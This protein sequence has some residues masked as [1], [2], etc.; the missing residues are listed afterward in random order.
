M[1]FEY[2]VGTK[3]WRE[4]CKGSAFWLAGVGCTPG[5]LGFLLALHSAHFAHRAAAH[6]PGALHYGTGLSPRFLAARSS[7]RVMV[8]SVSGQTS[9]RGGQPFA[10]RRVVVGFR[11]HSVLGGNGRA[12][13]APALPAPWWLPPESDELSDEAACDRMR[14]ATRM[15]VPACWGRREEPLHTESV[16][17]RIERASR[18]A[19][20]KSDRRE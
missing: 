6:A 7:A 16:R 4:V 11:W 1:I 3:S 17:R 13:I 12:Q 20:I 15:A 8:P 2:N 9:T 18:D 5:V 10:C 19:S 14:C